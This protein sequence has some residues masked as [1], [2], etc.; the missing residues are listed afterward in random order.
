[1]DYDLFRS[2]I[3]W[4]YVLLDFGN[5]KF[6]LF[7]ILVIFLF[8]SLRKN[9]SEFSFISFLCFSCFSL[10]IEMA[11][12][13]RER[14]LK[15]FGKV[16]VTII[17][18]QSRLLDSYPVAVGS[19]IL[20]KMLEKSIRVLLNRN[21][22]AVEES[23]LTLEEISFPNSPKIDR[24]SFLNFDLC[25]WATGPAP[26][27][28][29]ANIN[30]EHSKDGWLLVGDSLQSI[31]SPFLF[32]AGDCISIKQHE[33]AP[34]AGVYA[35]REGQVIAQNIQSL[36]QSNPFFESDVKPPTLSHYQPQ[37]DVLMLLNM[38]DGTA[39][40]SKYGMT[41]SG[42]YVFRLKDYM[43]KNFMNSFS[44]S[45]IRKQREISKNSSWWSKL[46]T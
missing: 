2:Y 23:K 22:I 37:T 10:G 19:A 18:S 20:S 45:S 42:D 13:F 41:M 9:D 34:K 15:T 1:M 11:F 7:P 4:A 6:S 21:V 16:E 8:F 33:K 38:G 5:E 28:V 46:W 12:C 26:P 36:I 29:L 44:S 39:I 40:G 32:A 43:D 14:Y 25:I 27:P 3:Y 35:V 30:A 31:S 17:G 24:A